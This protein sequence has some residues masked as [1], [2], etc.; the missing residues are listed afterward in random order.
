MTDHLQACQSVV[1]VIAAAIK[2]LEG[3]NYVTLSRVPSWI[4]QIYQVL[5]VTDD[6]DDDDVYAVDLKFHLNDQ[7]TCYF[8]DFFGSP[9]YALIAAALDVHYTLMKWCLPQVKTQVWEM[10]AEQTLTLNPN[11][12]GLSLA[13]LNSL[14]TPFCDW[15]SELHYEQKKK[16]HSE[17]TYNWPDP[18][19]FLL[20]LLTQPGSLFDVFKNTVIVFLS[21]PAMIER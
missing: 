8:G 19:K 3:E 18:I 5:R 20:P 21:C 6:N 2:Q 1:K 11:L 16:K 14:I 4:A 17:D 13:V 15:L 12:S 9:N 7:L 10:I